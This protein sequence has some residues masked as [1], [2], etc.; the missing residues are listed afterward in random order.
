MAHRATVKLALRAPAGV[1]LSSLP[2]PRLA[3]SLPPSSL[4]LARRLASYYPSLERTPKRGI[5]VVHLFSALALLGIGATS[6]GLY[7]FY[8]S[9]T[10]YPD[11]ASHPIRSKLRAALRAQHAGE[12]PRSSAFFSAA[13]DLALDLYARGELA[14]TKDEAV[15]RLTGIAIRWGAMWESVA[16]TARA[17]EAYDTGFQPVAALVDAHQLGTTTS[18]STATTERAPSPVEVRRGAAIAVKLGDLWLKQGGA[19]G[20]SR[21]GEADSEAERYY[22]WA[23]QELMRLS[24]SDEQKAKVRAQLDAQ[25]VGARA[26]GEAVGDKGEKK[27]DK[28]EDKNLKVPGWVGEVELVAAME[29]LGELYSRLGRIELAQPLLQ[30]AITILFPPP[31]KEGPKPPLPPIPQRCHAATLMNNLS[32][33][34]VSSAS[35]S[36]AQIQSSAGWSR[37]AL[38]VSNGCRSEAA[39]VRKK[40]DGAAAAGA[41]VPLA[42]REEREC[43]LTAIVASYNLGK[44]S[45]MS[46][47]PTSAE[48]WFVQSGTHATK[49]GLHDAARQ[50]NEAIRR[51][52]GAGARRAREAEGEGR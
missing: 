4:P 45:E 21:A 33:A 43:E 3:P 27:G 41:E 22:T 52:R 16:E 18:S 40:R 24:L 14:P 6:Y 19:P 28:E 36:A 51:L 15:E 20:A 31:P 23:V 35:P 50:S 32:S 34:L 49:L 11:T 5:K 38:I 39:K 12:H 26:A 46:K 17:I 44:L 2:R 48:Q 1:R 37:Q 8:Q 13:Y 29:R 30:Q 47:D 7:Q 9:F 10:A 42:E 25:E